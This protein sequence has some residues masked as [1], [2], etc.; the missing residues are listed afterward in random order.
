MKRVCYEV[1]QIELFN[2]YHCIIIDRHKYIIGKRCSEEE[3]NLCLGEGYYFKET[4]EVDMTPDKWFDKKRK[5]LTK[6][7]ISQEKEIEYDK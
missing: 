1:F 7:S 2:E 6:C 3:S 4:K 5:H